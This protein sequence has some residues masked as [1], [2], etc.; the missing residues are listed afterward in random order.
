MGGR[1]DGE[2]TRVGAAARCEPDDHRYGRR[3]D[4]DG[5]DLILPQSERVLGVIDPQKAK[6]E[7]PDRVLDSPNPENEAVGPAARVATQP[8][9]EPHAEKIPDH[10]V[11]DDEMNRPGLTEG[12]RVREADAESLGRCAGNRVVLAV[13]DVADPSDR[14]AERNTGSCGVGARPDRHAAPE[15]GDETAKHA[16]DG[17]APDRD[18]A[19][20]DE[21]D[22]LGMGEV[23]RQLI[24]DVN[25]P[26]A[27]DAAD[28][29]PRGDRPSVVLTDLPL[30]QTQGKGDTKEDADGREDAVPGK[31]YRAQMHI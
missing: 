3:R 20:P 30:E 28:D 19:G 9:R 15:G 31:R 4:E 25:E 22:L 27:D 23:V 12:V 21:E 17:R 7:A 11:G 24:D 18:A 13:D 1:S 14:E 16:P 2:T 6:E 29:S 8:E 5:D 10:V 26:S